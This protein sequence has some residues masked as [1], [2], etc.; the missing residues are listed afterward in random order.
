MSIDWF[1]FTAQVVNF[2]I[3]MVLLKKFLYGPII[4]AMKRRQEEIDNRVRAAESREQAAHEMKLQLQSQQ[5]ELES[6][7][8]QMLAEARQE[9]EALKQSLMHELR[10]EIDQ[11][12]QRWHQSLKQEQRS[13]VETLQQQIAQQLLRVVRQVL[14]ELSDSTLEERIV[15]AFTRQLEQMRKQ[16]RIEL[17][18]YLQNDSDGMIIQTAFDCPDDLRSRLIHSVHVNL[19]ESVPVQFETRP[20]LLAGIELKAGGYK[21]AWSIDGYLEGL[22]DA[23]RTAIDEELNAWKD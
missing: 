7:K 20:E 17:T 23:L 14:A 2:L 1:T 6:S 4:H 13:F 16:E 3:L 18:Q 21:L 8:Q 15:S 5:Q 10:Q 12:R 9:A 11:T 19:A 22:E